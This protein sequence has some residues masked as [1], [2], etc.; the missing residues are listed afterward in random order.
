[1]SLNY[2][3]ILDF[4]N[5]DRVELNEFGQF[6]IIVGEN[7]SGKTNFLESVFL[8]YQGKSFRKVPMDDLIQWE[9]NSFY[10]SGIFQNIKK[11]IG[12]GLQKR[13]LK[14]NN[15]VM[16]QKEFIHSSPVLSFLPED[17]TIVSGSPDERRDYMD[18]ALSLLDYDYAD[19]LQNYHKVLRQRNAQLKISSK[20]VY[21][22]NDDFIRYGSLIIEKRL[23]FMQ[24]S[25]KIIKNIYREF[26]NEEIELKYFNTFKIEGNVTESFKKALEQSAPME[27]LRKNSF[28]GPHRDNFEIQRLDKKARSFASQGQTRLLALAFK[29]CL[30]ENLEKAHHEKPVLLL[31]DVLLEL[32]GKSRKQFLNKIEPYQAFFT[33]TSLEIF[34]DLKNDVKIFEVDKGIIKEVSKYHNN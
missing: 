28:V 17:L 6:N 2:I 34:H 11:E 16:P 5:Y 22:W 21:L 14:L 10:I 20:E 13:I 9:K 25:G 7:G 18:R 31:D 12:C 33:A 19:A 24:T 8:L 3:K 29:L 30:L 4:R 27:K 1:M 32:D 23:I 26:Y 15:H